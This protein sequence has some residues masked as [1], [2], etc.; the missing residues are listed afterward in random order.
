VEAELFAVVEHAEAGVLDE[1]RDGLAGVCASYS[2][3]LS[4]DHDDAVGRD[5]A[6]DRHRTGRRWRRGVG[7]ESRPAQ[8]ATLICVDG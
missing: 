6:F 1:D 2:N 4:G 7:R 3:L 8:L 5:A